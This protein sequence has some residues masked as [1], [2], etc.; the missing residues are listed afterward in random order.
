MANLVISNSNKAFQDMLMS[1]LCQD[2]M[3]PLSYTDTPS[4]V[5]PSSVAP[6]AGGSPTED[7]VCLISGEPLEE[8]PVVLECGHQFNYF[9]IFN[10]VYRQKNNKNHYETIHL[11]KTELKCPYCRNIQPK[12]L[13]W[14]ENYAQIR[15]VNWPKKYSMFPKKCTYVGVDGE[16]GAGCYGKHCLTHQR[17]VLR[18]EKLKAALEAKIEKQNAKKKQKQNAKAIPAHNS[19]GLD[20]AEVSGGGVETSMKGCCAFLKSG[21]RKGQCCGATIKDDAKGVCGRHM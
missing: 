6:K 5:A 8:E 3:D 21:A 17:A 4:S 10:E 7:K 14:R 20:F 9:N 12:L 18:E 2:I 16:C 13:Y 15:G 19:S 11:S 1:A